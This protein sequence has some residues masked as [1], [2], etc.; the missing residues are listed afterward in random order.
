[1][2]REDYRVVDIL[3]SQ[4]VDLGVPV[5][6]QFSLSQTFEVN[7]KM[8]IK[9]ILVPMYV[10]DVI[11]SVNILLRRPDDLVATWRIGSDTLGIETQRI[12]DVELKLE[13][14]MELEGQYEL[15]ID[16][17]EISHTEKDRAPRVFVEKDDS[18]Y[19]GGSYKIA[20]QD[21]AGDISL[22]VIGERTRWQKMRSDW[23]EDPL[24]GV[25]LGSSWLLLLL[26]AGTAPHVLLRWMV[27]SK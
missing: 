21:K 13:R 19:E 18:K 25:V 2:Q 8:E 7:P 27:K 1:M 12:Y 26:V 20:G 23:Q 15:E 11:R 16:G 6:A 9:K 17:R 4:E 10:P 24:A 5:Y 3:A 14:R 22:Q